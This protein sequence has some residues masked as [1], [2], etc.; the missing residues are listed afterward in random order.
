[1]GWDMQDETRGN[2]RRE[3]VDLNGGGVE[4]SGTIGMYG[5]SRLFVPSGFSWSITVPVLRCMRL[6]HW[7]KAQR[8][9][10]IEIRI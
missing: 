7:K 5:K 2:G 8:P 1:M 10:C 4:T 9:M 3:Q 6:R